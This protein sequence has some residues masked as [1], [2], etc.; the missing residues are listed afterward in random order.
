MGDKKKGWFDLG[1]DGSTVHIKLQFPNC[2]SQCQLCGF[3]DYGEKQRKIFNEKGTLEN[4]KVPV[5]TCQIMK[6][7]VDSD[8]LGQFFSS[9]TGLMDKSGG[10]NNGKKGG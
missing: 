6:R 5:V 7:L 10:A 9:I 4:M 1:I 3:A 2:M 8:E